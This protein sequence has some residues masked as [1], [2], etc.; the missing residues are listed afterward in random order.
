MAAIETSSNAGSRSATMLSS[1]RPG[2]RASRQDSTTPKMQAPCALAPLSSWTVARQVFSSSGRQGVAR[3]E[4]T[5]NVGFG[6]NLEAQSRRARP[7]EHLDG[8]QLLPAPRD[9]IVPVSDNAIFDRSDVTKAP[10]C[11]CQ[12]SVAHVHCKV[13]EANCRGD[14]T[15]PSRPARRWDHEKRWREPEVEELAV[16]GR[17]GGREPLILRAQN[18]SLDASSRQKDRDS[19]WMLLSRRRRRPGADLAIERFAVD[20]TSSQC[21]GRGPF[22]VSD[23]QELSSPAS[24]VRLAVPLRLRDRELQHVEEALDRV[25][26]GVSERMPH[27]GFG[28]RSDR[29]RVLRGLRQRSQAV[30]RHPWVLSELGHLDPRVL[31]LVQQTVHQVAQRGVPFLRYRRS[32]TAATSA[33]PPRSR[34]LHLRRVF[35][36]FIHLDNLPVPPEGQLPSNHTIQ[37]HPC[38]ETLAS[39]PLS[40]R[41]RNGTHPLPKYRPPDR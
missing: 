17:G 37:C 9:G 20:G 24:L 11:H 33:W 27:V 23:S 16:D 38:H 1:D 7:T 3:H 32:A 6:G 4:Q 2:P 22:E 25:A 13:C 18:V 15:K 21:H 36:L 40:F 34:G 29:L 10:L 39:A 30:G 26:D 41:R 28:D 14:D 5:I 35:D 19:R 8:R 31:V 12:N